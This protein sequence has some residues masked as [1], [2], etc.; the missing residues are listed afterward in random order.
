MALLAFLVHKFDQFD[1]PR[2]TS[3]PHDMPAFSAWNE[4]LPKFSRK[5]YEDLAQ[6]L[7]ENHE[8]MEQQGIIHEDLK[9][10]L[11][12]FSLDL[13]ARL[14]FKSLPLSSISSLK[15]FHSVFNSTCRTY[16]PHKFPFEGYCEYY[17]AKETLKSH[18]N[19]VEDTND[20]VHNISSI[21]RGYSQINYEHVCKRK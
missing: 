17:D 5:E 9:M 16:Y 6:H 11:F 20:L 14:W 3:Y 1:F 12:L 8:C 10:K 21:H 18:D 13:E 4:Y 15:Y 7:Q 2:I 19:L